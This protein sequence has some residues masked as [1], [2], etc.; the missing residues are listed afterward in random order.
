MS[1][2]KSSDPA[3]HE[4][5]LMAMTVHSVRVPDAD[6]RRTASGRFKMLL[7]LL[8]CAAPV[9]AS[10]FT[11]YV[12]RPEGR[13]NYSTLIQPSRPWP[14]TLPMVNLDGQGVAAA[15]LKGQWLLVAVSEGPCE[16]ECEK[17]LYMQRQLREMLG[18]DSD[19]LD[20][21]WLIASD[22]P[23]VPR[24]RSA[25]EAAGA[26]HILR[27]PAAELAQWLHAEAGQRL[28]DHLY[29]VDPMGDWMM[30]SPANPLPEKLKRD[31]DRL[32]RASAGWDKA[33]R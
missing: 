24:L 9:V 7:V 33:G 27:V 4:S 3:E 21:V 13:T 26:V 23:V 28:S 20:K 25:L 12:I 18:R 22:A 14:K 8:A 6:R 1:G 17:R 29:V 2:S 16:S 5:E 32:L 11:Y 31:L 10:Y 19:R 15:S 30:R